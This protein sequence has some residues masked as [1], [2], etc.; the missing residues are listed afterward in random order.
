M[1]ARGRERWVRDTR[2]GRFQIRLAGELAV[3]CVVEGTL[4]V[5]DLWADV[6]AA[7]HGLAISGG[8]LR[9]TAQ[10][11]IHLGNG[12]DGAVV[13][14]LH[15][16]VWLEIAGIEQTQQCLLWIGVRD[17]SIGENFFAAL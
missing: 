15:Y 10:R 1:L 7:A 17:H 9:Q 11:E 2:D 3:L 6:D 12:S 14:R 16:K 8:E 4:Q 5:I 13:A